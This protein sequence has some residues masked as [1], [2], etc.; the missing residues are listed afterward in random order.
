MYKT[1]KKLNIPE[2]EKTAHVQRLQNK[3]CLNGDL[4]SQ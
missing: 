2:D 4:A 3:C 1:L